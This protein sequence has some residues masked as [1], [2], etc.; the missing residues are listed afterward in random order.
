MR[1]RTYPV[2]QGQENTDMYSLDN[3]GRITIA[4]VLAG[5]KYKI[6]DFVLSYPFRIQA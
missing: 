1:E 2:Y 3:V 5:G 4:M 6:I